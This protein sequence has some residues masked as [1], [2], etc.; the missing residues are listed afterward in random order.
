[1]SETE[2]RIEKEA[3]AVTWACDKFAN[4][5]IGIHII[6]ESDHKPLLSLLN[7]KHLED[8]PP[9]IMR[10]R[11]RLARFSYSVVHSP[12]KLMYTADT[13]SRAPRSIVDNDQTLEEE[14]ECIMEVTVNSLPATQKRLQEEKHRLQ[15]QYVLQLIAK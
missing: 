15:I 14:T 5:I 10:F 2:K 4:D 3:L 12:G 11:L 9:R 8:L 6:I 13:L 1:M 7:T